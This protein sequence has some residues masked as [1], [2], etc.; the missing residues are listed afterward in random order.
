MTAEEISRVGAFQQFD[1]QK[2]EQQG[3][4]LGLVLVQK[5]VARC[6]GEFSLSSAP[7]ERTQASLR[8]LLDSLG[9]RLALFADLEGGLPYGIED[10]GSHRFVLHGPGE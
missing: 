4:G 3:L 10:L 1:R 6:H 8:N 2:Y 9:P 7:G 5:L